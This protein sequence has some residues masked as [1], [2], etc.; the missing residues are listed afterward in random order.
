MNEGYKYN[1]SFNPSAMSEESKH[2]S[3]NS[4]EFNGPTP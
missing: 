3:S 1:T 4:I 2:S